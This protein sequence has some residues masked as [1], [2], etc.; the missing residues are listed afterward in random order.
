[1]FTYFPANFMWSSAVNLSLMAGGELGQIDRW[2]APL[3]DGRGGRD[4]RDGRDAEPDTDAWT[5]A[6]NSA[7]AE[8]EQ[9]A[10]DDLR[11]GFA[12]SASARYLRAST[13]YL[14]GERQTPPGPAKTHGYL[15]A[16]RAFGKAAE[17]MPH[18]IE[19]VEIGSP[20]GILPG[21][22]IPAARAQG[23]A[24]VVIFYNGFDVTKLGHHLRQ[25]R[26]DPAA[27]A[28]S[29]AI[30]LRAAATISSLVFA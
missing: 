23:P 14:T 11:R 15:A 28:C 13:Y 26:H 21:Y 27:P 29:P 2:L 7:A 10:A 30:C 19:R 8:Q 20:D 5:K 1:M 17:Y 16:L 12:R 3:R 4:G 6:W 24:P 22:L 18:P 9:H 25:L